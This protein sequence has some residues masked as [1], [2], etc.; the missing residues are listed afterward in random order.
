VTERHEHV[1]IALSRV[2]SKMLSAEDRLALSRALDNLDL[3]DEDELADL[4]AAALGWFE[5]WLM[6][7]FER[8]PE[9]DAQVAALVKVVADL[10]A[11]LAWIEAGADFTPVASGLALDEPQAWAALLND[12]PEARL[13]WLK[14]ISEQGHRGMNCFINN[15]EDRLVQLSARCRRLEDQVRGLGGDPD[16]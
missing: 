15:H 7:R 6:G 8:A 1:H 13:D 4:S 9:P 10:R 11:R 16:A 12:R 3:V 5:G 14:S 2:P